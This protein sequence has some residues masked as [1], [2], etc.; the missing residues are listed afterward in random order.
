MEMRSGWGPEH[1][2]LDCGRSRAGK[3]GTRVS[4]RE[5]GEANVGSVVGA[6]CIGD[7]GRV[8]WGPNHMDARRGS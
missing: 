6:T 2:Q 3:E 8:V 7:S 4:I 1:P 5:E